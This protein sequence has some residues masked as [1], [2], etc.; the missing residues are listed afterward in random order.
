MLI[1]IFFK[2]VVILFTLS[3]CIGCATVP[4][5]SVE[6]SQEVGKGIQ[7]SRRSQVNLLNKYFETKK[8]QIDL[9][10]ESEFL[11]AYIENIL[12]AGQRAPA[13]PGE[14]LKQ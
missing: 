7:E 13:H 11:P 14:T 3:I 5:E 6:I 10:A 12:G 9:W 8:A 4:R 1:N 2:H